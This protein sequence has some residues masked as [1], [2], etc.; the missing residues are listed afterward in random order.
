VSSSSASSR[1]GWR[2]ACGDA[3]NVAVS[4]GC[5][6]GATAGTCTAVLPAA[7]RAGS[8]QPG[9]RD[10]GTRP[11]SRG[12]RTTASTNATTRPGWAPDL[13]A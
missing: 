11:R 7:A 3:D 10:A 8:A 6:V 13:E 4:S 5:T 9:P 12:D 1:P 2:S